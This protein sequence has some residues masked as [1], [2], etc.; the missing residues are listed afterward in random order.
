MMA[1]VACF[2]VSAVLVVVLQIIRLF[3][4]NPWPVSTVL[5]LWIL[6]GLG[7]LVLEWLVGIL[8]IRHASRNHA[9]RA[10]EPPPTDSHPHDPDPKTPLWARWYIESIPT[11]G[12]LPISCSFIEFDER[13]D[14]LD[15]EQHRH[16]YEKV[17]ALARQ[18]NPLKVLLFVHGWRHTG[19]SQN[20]NA[21]NA[22][23]AQLRDAE[24]A[25]PAPHRVHGIY[26]AWRGASLRQVVPNDEA[27]STVREA[28]GDDLTTLTER[29]PLPLLTELLES[30]SYFN[31]KKVPEHMFSGTQLSRSVFSCALAA[32][33]TK[34]DCEVL[35]MGHSFGGLMLERT[36]QNAAI[37]ELTQAWP[38]GKERPDTPA[39]PLPFDTI[40][41]VNSA[42]PSIYAKQFQSYLAAHRQA[43]VDARTPHADSPFV[44]SLTST[45]DW[46]TGL[47]HP[48]ANWFTFL[49]PSL[50]RLYS[51]ADFT[52][53]RVGDYAQVEIP[54]Y[55]Y[56]RHTPG[57]N[58]L[59]VN[60][61]IEPVA[62]HSGT[63]DVKWRQIHK[64]L[65]E[66]KPDVLEFETTSADR[67]TQGWRIVFPP[68]ST[69]VDDAFSR[70]GGRR[71][72]VW[73]QEPAG[74]GHYRYKD[75][76]Y[77]ILQCQKAIISSHTDI[78][79]QAAMD[80]YA[81]LHRISLAARETVRHH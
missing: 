71:P 69:S 60:R 40:L 51:G 53:E 22:F 18:P 25:G 65:T 63:T 1:C 78:W 47:T 39:N 62:G 67:T 14:Y 36:V 20:V 28:Y 54:Q 46:A 42:A 31:R 9:F 8:V 38:W 41:L 61:F 70:Y 17:L 29:A 59:L 4:G 80:T 75:T 50:R 32:K 68:A 26:L 12:K 35:L 27:W 33:Q 23:L 13:G 57:H 30:F 3:M 15:F 43:M 81:A 77:W 37:G 34:P 55:Y 2:L 21:F 64:N 44:F 6:L 66:P 7:L 5:E 11:S 72:V 24:A 52:L 74:S 16:A 48:I 76:A 58:P 49:L 56:Y 10:I 79:S 73:T 19:Q 45:A